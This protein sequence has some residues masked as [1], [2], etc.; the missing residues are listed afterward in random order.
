MKTI[1]QTENFQLLIFQIDHFMRNLTSNKLTL[2]LQTH[3][4]ILKPISNMM[5][6]KLMRGQLM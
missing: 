5:R 4:Y 1:S 2:K 6:C 3:K